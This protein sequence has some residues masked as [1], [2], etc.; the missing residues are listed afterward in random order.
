MV[1]E[2]TTIWYS[3]GSTQ[4]EGEKNS[5]MRAASLVQ[6]SPSLC[7]QTPV[8]LRCSA[9]SPLQS[10]A[11]KRPKGCLR[12]GVLRQGANPFFHLIWFGRNTGK[13][14]KALRPHRWLPMQTK[15]RGSD[16][17]VGLRDIWPSEACSWADAVRTRSILMKAC[18]EVIKVR[19]SRAFRRKAVA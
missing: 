13:I 19:I 2:R 14:R 3:W 5:V 18:W 9:T 6:E 11:L 10:V 8:T 4:F 1:Y 12:T 16:F 17:C 7:V 15:W